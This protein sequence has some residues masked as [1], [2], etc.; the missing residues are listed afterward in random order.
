[1]IYK[2]R[3][4]PRLGGQPLGG[5]GDAVQGADSLFVLA[6][7]SIGLA[8]FTGITAALYARGTWHPHDTRGTR[9]TRGGPFP[10]SS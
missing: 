2:A 3:C 4:R 5:R 1:V 6:E 10:C 8:G 7:I 9:T